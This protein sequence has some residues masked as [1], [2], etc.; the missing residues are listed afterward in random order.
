MNLKY[1]QKCR[2]CD[3]PFLKQVLNL[4]GH[5]LHGNF[6]NPNK[7]LAPPKRKIPVEL[8]Q[9]DTS[10]QSYACGLTQLSITTPP[11]ILYY[12]YG[13]RSSRSQTM[14]NWLQ[15]IVNK[16]M[17][18]NPN[19]E[20]TID[21][22]MNDGFML[23]CYPEHVKKTGVDGG[24]I[25]TEEQRLGIEVINDFYPCNGLRG[26]YFDCFTAI[27]CLYDIDDINTFIANVKQNID[28]GGLFVFEVAYLPTI[29]RNV[30]YSH[31]VHE[32]L[33]TYHLGALDYLLEKHGLKIFRAEITPTNGGSILCFACHDHNY[34]EFKT[35][36]NELNLK[37]IKFDEFE[38]GIA[39]G[40]PFKGNRFQF[41]V[42]K[43]ANE[44]NSMVKEII[45][46]GKTIHLYSATAF[47][48]STAA[49]HQ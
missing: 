6:Y 37:K 26:R 14:K 31:F 18:I 47:R 22:G 7:E 10:K 28:V 45:S 41:A 20:T 48:K 46:S 30:D 4:G 8:M 1:I 19:I 27:A 35:D 40:V 36:E 15:S 23:N 2:I 21:V 11:E 16:I 12:D 32:H 5:W 13:Y 38:M 33:E 49:V 9:C 42:D 29:I 24:S 34:S 44:L 3:N 25:P 43:H 39:D 17:E